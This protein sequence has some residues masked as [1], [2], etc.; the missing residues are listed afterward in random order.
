MTK[1]VETPKPANN[2]GLH[3]SIGDCKYETAQEDCDEMQ[4]DEEDSDVTTDSDVSVTP[5]YETNTTN[6]KT[7]SDGSSTSTNSLEAA[8]TKNVHKK[9]PGK[10]KSIPLVNQHLLSPPPRTSRQN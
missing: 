9:T 3:I 5:N 10:I 4:L 7:R 1:N 6:H 2:S 8:A